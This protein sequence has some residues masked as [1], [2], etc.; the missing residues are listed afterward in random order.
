MQLVVVAGAVRRWRL[1]DELGEPCA[2]GAE[3]R[4]A[5]RQANV[6][7]AQ[8]TP[9]QHGLCPLDPPGHEVGVRRLGVRLAEAAAEVR[10][11]HQGCAGERRHVERLRVLSVHLVACPA[12]SAQFV[13]IDAHVPILYFL[14]RDA[15]RQPCQYGRAPWAQSVDEVASSRD[16][17]PV[18]C[19]TTGVIS[20]IA[21]SKTTT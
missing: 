5:D 10:R 16:H 19:R 13:D 20:S 7:H 12:Q 6:C 21:L 9:A 1:T 3:A 15:Q 17:V 14:A 11:R 8:V 18:N 4:P 2:E